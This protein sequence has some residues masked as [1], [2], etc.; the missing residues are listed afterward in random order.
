MILH[1]LPVRSR[2]IEFHF[3]RNNRI[4]FLTVE[5]CNL[6][7]KH[8]TW[9]QRVWF[10]NLV[11][12]RGEYHGVAGTVMQDASATDLWYQCAVEIAGIHVDELVVRKIVLHIK[13]EYGV[14]NIGATVHRDLKEPVDWYAFTPYMPLAVRS[15]QFYCVYAGIVT[16]RPKIISGS[17][18]DGLS[19]GDTEFK[20]RSSNLSGNKHNSACDPSLPKAVVCMLCIR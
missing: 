11:I 17:V 4:Q 5:C 7:G 14:S 10:S 3:G 18:H 1:R 20:S 8:V 6:L 15:A 9:C 13:N 12:H 16:C 2:Q 19:R